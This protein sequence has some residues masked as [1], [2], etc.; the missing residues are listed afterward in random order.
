VPTPTK[1]VK[2]MPMQESRLST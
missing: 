1:S 2:S